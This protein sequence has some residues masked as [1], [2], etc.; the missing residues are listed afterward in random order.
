MHGVLCSFS[1]ASSD[2]TV[3]RQH[4]RTHKIHAR[5]LF[6]SPARLLL[7]RRLLQLSFWGIRVTEIW[8][9]ATGSAP[10]SPQ[11]SRVTCVLKTSA[12]AATKPAVLYTA[13]TAHTDPR[14]VPRRDTL[15]RTAAV[16]AQ[17]QAG[18]HEQRTCAGRRDCHG[19]TPLTEGSAGGLRTSKSSRIPQQKRRKCNYY[20][21]L[22]NSISL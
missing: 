7:N 17:P 6:V 18:P 15:G 2:F 16:L 19:H 4:R 11:C 13:H 21:T 9:C 22:S 20:D 12:A 10:P 3:R 8:G 1:K 14:A 5:S